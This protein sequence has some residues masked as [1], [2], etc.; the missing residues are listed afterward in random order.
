ML[1]LPKSVRVLLASEPVDMRNSI[2]G[3]SAIVRTVWKEN[4]FSGD[5][6]AF[7]SK[8]KDRAKLLCWDSGG[9]VLFYKR[10]EQGRFKLPDVQDGALGAHLDST[11]LAMLLDGIDLSH[12]RRPKKWKP[13]EEE[14]DRQ[15]PE[16]LIEP[17]KWQRANRR[18]TASTARKPRGSAASSRTSKPRSTSSTTPSS[19]RRAKSSRASKSSYAAARRSRAKRR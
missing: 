9:F 6:F 3:L 19:G 13:P 1:F 14:G 16:N 4:I 11:Q 2:D 7:I 18:I 5:I 12:V 10:L 15:I 17:R 8:S